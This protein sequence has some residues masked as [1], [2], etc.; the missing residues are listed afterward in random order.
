LLILLYYSSGT[1]IETFCRPDFLVWI[2][3]LL[4]FWGEESASSGAK[5]DLESKFQQIDPVYFD[6]VAFMV[7][8]ANN[9]CKIRFYAVEGGS[10]QPDPF[11]PLTEQLDITNIVNRFLILRTT[12]NIARLL[13]T[14]KDTLPAMTVAYPL[15]K[16]FKSGT[17]VITFGFASVEKK[18]P[19]AHLPLGGSNL[20]ARINFLS[21]MYSHAAGHRGLARVMAGP[22]LTSG[23]HYKVIFKTK[24]LPS[25]KPRN[26]DDVRAMTKD[27]VS[28][29]SWLHDGG[30]LHCDVRLANIVY[31][32][33]T[34][35]WTLIDFEHGQSV[36]SNNVG[37]PLKDWDHGTCH[38]GVYT[39]ASEMYQLG[40][41]LS[42]LTFSQLGRDFVARLRRKEMTAKESLEHEWIRDLA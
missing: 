28:A 13:V 6:E 37:S 40:G 7:C 32:P 38:D 22:K 11:V 26:E 36:T 21:Q 29:L 8:Y 12:I 30:Y 18:I 23:T 14:I 15:A 24:G 4:V 35:N 17:S 5:E 9:G 41:M 34:K 27:V 10:K 39:T 1:S 31:D 42:V 16:R 19:V 2:R 3:H 20:Q 33:S 25:I